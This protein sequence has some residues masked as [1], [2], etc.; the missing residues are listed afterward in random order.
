[1]VTRDNRIWTVLYVVG[2]TA[3]AGLIAGSPEQY[4]MGPIAFK[5]LQLLATGLVAA[6]KM[7]NSPLRGE[8]DPDLPPRP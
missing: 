7:G 1:M 3:A 6:G 8:N 2:L 4:G 5:W